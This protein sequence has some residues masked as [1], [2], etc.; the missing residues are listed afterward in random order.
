MSDA[1]SVLFYE[2]R[3]VNSTMEIYYGISI[4]TFY[5]VKTTIV[6][7]STNNS[8]VSTSNRIITS[9]KSEGSASSAMVSSMKMN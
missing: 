8:V 6:L 2:G 3:E 1:R 4:T 9:K 5:T 7:P